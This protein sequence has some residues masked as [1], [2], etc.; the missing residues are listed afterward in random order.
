MNATANQ[1]TFVIMKTN[2]GYRVCSPLNPANQFVVSGLP[3]QAQCTCPEF[4]RH[5]TDPNYICPHIEAV[6]NEAGRSA[7]ANGRARGNGSDEP[8]TASPP[9]PGNGRA[10][11]GAT[12]VLKRSVS[13]DGRIDSLSIE[14]SCPL[15]AK[16]SQEELILRADRMLQVQGGI[17][18]R[19]LKN[20]P[21]P[22]QSRNGNGGA[23]KANNGVHN[24]D[25]QAAVPGQL[26]AVASM[27]T[28]RGRSLFI[29]IQVNGQVLK[30]FGEVSELKQ[31]VAAAG[32]PSVADHLADGFALNLPC[33]VVTRP[34]GK[35]T[36]V[37][38]LLPVGNGG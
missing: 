16:L 25:Q 34:N 14:L 35:Y 18:E 6:Q 11:N 32:Y 1:P 26:L 12:M 5:D 31:A 15:G 23:P 2:E 17:A 21:K 36:N 20:G 28:R 38:R 22:A 8:A 33:R 10:D 4:E 30:L 7:G 3:G 9:K 19:F 27:N 13:P 29:N 37:D 24:G